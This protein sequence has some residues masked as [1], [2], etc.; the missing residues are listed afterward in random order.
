MRES[1]L[2]LLRGEKPDEVVWTADISYWITG[3][4]QSGKFNRSL[5]TEE[6]Y[7]HFSQQLGILPYYWYAKFWLGEPRYRRVKIKT[8][9]QGHQTEVTWHTPVGELSQITEFMPESCSGGCTKHPVESEEDLKVLIALLE[10]R[11]LEPA[12]LEDYRRRCEWWAKFDGLPCI[13]LPRSPL[14]AFFYEWAGVQNA[15]YLLADHPDLVQR[16]LELLEEQ[17]EPILEAVCQA[18]PPLVHFPDNLSSENLTG[19]FDQHM[20]ARY[21]RRVERLHSAGVRCAVHLDGTVRGLL[22]RL[23]ACGIDAVEALTPQ[24]VGD[25]AVE[26]MRNVAGSPTVILWGGVPGAMF[27]PPFDWPTMKAHVE[28]LLAS[29]Q[30]TP[31]VV[32]V[33]DQVPPDGDIQMCRQIADLLR[34]A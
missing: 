19:C 23:A 33:A 3:Q 28:K 15:V 20:A 11:H 13:A 9:Q 26:E 31:F 24:P 21:R 34:N 29:W 10:D 7:L 12:G 17:E 30:G 8:R 6:G 27:A 2:K 32:G 5:D 18:A 16:I 22:P 14:S 4:R 25:V 1:L